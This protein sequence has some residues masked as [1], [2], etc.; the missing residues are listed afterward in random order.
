MLTIS[1]LCRWLC[2]RTLAGHAG[3]RGSKPGGGVEFRIIYV[4]AHAQYGS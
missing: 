3:D 4:N 2:A 1:K